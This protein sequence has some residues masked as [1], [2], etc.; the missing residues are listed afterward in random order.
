MVGDNEI[1]NHDCN[2]IKYIR[3]VYIYIVVEWG[4]R[5]TGIFAAHEKI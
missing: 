4:Q 2:L 5:K 3:K 1:K